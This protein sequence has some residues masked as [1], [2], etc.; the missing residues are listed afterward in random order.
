[1]GLRRGFKTEANWYAYNVRHDMGLS[2]HHPIC[3]WAL[4]ELLGFKVFP[5]SSYR[6]LFGREV[7]CLYGFGTEV[8]FSAVTVPV[9]EFSFIIHNDMH[10]KKRQAADIAHEAA[11]ALLMHQPDALI[12][13]GSQRGF[14]KQDE[15]EASWLGPALLVSEE[16]ALHI[17]RHEISF[18]EASEMY[19]ASEDLIKMRL[20]VTGALKRANA[21]RGVA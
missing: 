10:S 2:P 15:E 16:A 1:M 13:G 7:S 17:A 18:A 19:G 8:S 4:A 20:N 6:R 9:G 5:L 21:V 14:R 11:H 3:A 12:A